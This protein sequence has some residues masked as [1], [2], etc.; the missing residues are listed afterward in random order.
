MS[1]SD[2]IFLFVV[3]IASSSSFFVSLLFAY[4][5]PTIAPMLVPVIK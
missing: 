4:R 3:V 2:I 1:I 5:L